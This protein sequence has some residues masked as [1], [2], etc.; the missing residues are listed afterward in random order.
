VAVGSD[1][2]MEE[3]EKEKME[4]EGLRKASVSRRRPPGLW[5]QV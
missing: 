1:V 4:E 3:V 2:E 5:R